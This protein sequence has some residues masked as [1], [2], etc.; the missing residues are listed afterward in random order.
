MT[1]RRVDAIYFALVLIVPVIG[2]YAA[3]RWSENRDNQPAMDFSRPGRALEEPFI[4]PLFAPRAESQTL[5]RAQF[6]DH[7]ESALVHMRSALLASSTPNE[8][9]P[10]ER[11]TWVFE[12]ARADR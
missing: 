3:N 4:F 10:P 11:L 5:L 8:I 2:Y 6:A 7:M 12:Q 1:N 9:R